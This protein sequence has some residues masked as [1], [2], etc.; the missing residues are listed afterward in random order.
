MKKRDPD[1]QSP[2]PH[3]GPDDEHLPTLVEL[4]GFAE[5]LLD[6]TNSQTIRKP[7][8]ARLLETLENIVT[9][10]RA[11]PTGTNGF[12]EGDTIYIAPHLHG[13]RFE[14]TARHE[15]GHWL[16]TPKCLPAAVQEETLKQFG[17]F[18][19]APRP[20][21]TEHLTRANGMVGYAMQGILDEWGDVDE[22]PGFPIKLIIRVLHLARARASLW[23]GN[24]RT[25]I[26]G[27]HYE[28]NADGDLLTER[29]LVDRVRETQRP[30]MAGV[31]A[32]WPLRWE[33]HMAVLVVLDVGAS[34]GLF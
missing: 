10:V 5:D 8:A 15:L 30:A 34:R 28:L 6:L 4:E 14:R 22:S 2:E 16:L 24:V 19:L 31:R 7:T 23:V 26:G 18:W 13:L 33:G 21:V 9:V 3:D 20:F 32:G 1:D 27:G 11:S 12:H 29:D 25:E 17:V